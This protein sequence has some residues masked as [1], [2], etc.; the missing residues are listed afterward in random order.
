MPAFEIGRLMLR[1]QAAGRR[2]E[3]HKDITQS[4]PGVVL[5]VD[6]QEVARAPTVGE[7]LPEVE[8]WLASDGP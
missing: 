2:T 6:D 7:L 8:R 5:R 3:L 1:L 4:R